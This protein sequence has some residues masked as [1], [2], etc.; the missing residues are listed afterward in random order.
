M[1]N[2]DWVLPTLPYALAIASTVGM[3]ASNQAHKDLLENYRNLLDDFRN[4]ANTVIL[5]QRFIKRQGLTEEYQDWAS[6]Q[7]PP[8]DSEGEISDEYH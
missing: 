7:E 1:V 2:L 4:A 5:S 8:I 6:E 3:Y